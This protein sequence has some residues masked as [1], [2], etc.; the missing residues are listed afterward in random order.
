MRCCA[1]AGVYQVGEG[2][3]EGLPHLRSLP[4]VCSTATG[5]HG[6]CKAGCLAGTARVFAPGFLLFLLQGSLPASVARELRV[7][8]APLSCLNGS[9]AISV[10]SSGGGGDSG[11]KGGSS[12]GVGSGGTVAAAGHQMR[13]GSGGVGYGVLLTDGRLRIAAAGAQHVLHHDWSTTLLLQ[14]RWA[15]AFTPNEGRQS[16]SSPSVGLLICAP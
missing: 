11:D 6:Y 12:G 3:R 1:A 5:E 16:L 13:G 15:F 2:L 4:L 10:D 7:P 8:H 14:V 9:S